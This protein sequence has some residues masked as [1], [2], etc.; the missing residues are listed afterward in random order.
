[1]LH[2]KTYKKWEDTVYNTQNK[3]TIPDT[4]KGGDYDDDDETIMI[5]V[6]I[7]QVTNRTSL[8]TLKGSSD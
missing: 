2:R 4:M 7:M 1:M 8:I 3:Q 6:L 5:I